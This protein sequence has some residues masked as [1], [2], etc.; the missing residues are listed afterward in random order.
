MPPNA[1]TTLL[2]PTFLEYRCLVNLGHTASV[3]VF[4]I[5][6][7]VLQLRLLAFPMYRR[8]SHSSS[9]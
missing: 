5:H 8:L 9:A 7:V 2:H 6:G 4:L 1:P 3:L